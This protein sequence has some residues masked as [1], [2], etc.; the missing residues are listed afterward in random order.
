MFGG[1]ALRQGKDNKQNRDLK[2]ELKASRKDTGIY[3]RGL[4]TVYS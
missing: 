2:E 1:K 3:L 4:D